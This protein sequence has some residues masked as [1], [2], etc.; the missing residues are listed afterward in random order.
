MGSMGA[1]GSIDRDLGVGRNDTRVCSAGAG[2]WWGGLASAAREER[3]EARFVVHSGAPSSRRP[4]EEGR[5][6]GR[7]EGREEMREEGGLS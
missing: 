5:Q 7:E 1:A 2:W 3:S 6:E 4:G